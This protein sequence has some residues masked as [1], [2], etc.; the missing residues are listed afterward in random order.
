MGFDVTWTPE[1]AGAGWELPLP[2]DMAER[3]TEG[4]LSGPLDTA[5]WQ[6]QL[7]G[8]PLNTNTQLLW[9]RKSLVDD[10][11]KTWD[12]LIASGER[13]ADEGK[14]SMIGVQAAQYEGSVVWLNSMI[15]WAG[16]QLVAPDG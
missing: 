5:T 16:G 15:A 10:L 9:Y 12:D 6:D 1:F 2:E 3:V 7:Y 11:P 14:P 4:T 13:L 8:A